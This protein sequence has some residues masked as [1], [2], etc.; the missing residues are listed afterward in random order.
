MRLN[1]LQIIAGGVFLA[2]SIAGSG[3]LPARQIPKAGSLRKKVDQYSIERLLKGE[4]AITTSLADAL[5]E[6]SFLDD[7]DPQFPLPLT[8]MPRA[9]NGNFI[10]IR[11]G[12][13]EFK[14]QSYCLKA[15]TYQPGQGEG[16]LYAP[17]KGP[18]AQIVRHILERS[19]DHPE[20]PQ[21]DIQYLLWAILA[22]T[23]ISAMSRSNQLTALRLLSKEEILALNSGTL[24]IIPDNVLNRALG[25]LP[26]LIQNIIRA[27]NQIRGLLTRA[28]A[29]YDQIERLAVLAGEPPFDKDGRDI[30][31]GRWSYHPNRYFVRYYPSGY[32]VTRRQI[33]VS[34]PFRIHRDSLGRITSIVQD[35]ENRMD[36]EYD[37]T[38]EPLA[39]SGPTPFQA[40]AFRSIRYSGDHPQKL[41]V[42]VKAE[43][44]D[45]GWSFVGNP[46]GQP[47]AEPSSIRYSNL[48]PRLDRAKTYEKELG[49]ISS[50]LKNTGGNIPGD[51]LETGMGIAHLAE[52]LKDIIAAEG[53]PENLSSNEAFYF[54][55]R[56]WMA[57]VV[58][59]AGT[60]GRSAISGRAQTFPTGYGLPIGLTTWPELGW[61]F[62]KGR[63]LVAD[64]SGFAVEPDGQSS[65]SGEGSGSQTGTDVGTPGNSGRQRLGQSDRPSGKPPCSGVV[66]MA[67]GDVQINGQPASDNMISD[68]NGAV[69]T[70][71][72]KS[73]VQID[74]S[75]GSV[76][77]L[78]SNSTLDL[79]GICTQASIGPSWVELA[80]GRIHSLFYKVFGRGPEVRTGNAVNTRGEPDSMQASSF[81]GILLASLSKQPQLDPREIELE[82]VYEELKP[83]EAE[84]ALAQTAFFESIEPH[85]YIYVKVTKGTVVV[86]I[87]DEPEIIVH[88]GEHIYEQLSRYPNPPKNRD[89]VVRVVK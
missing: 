56:A 75:D 42:K 36:V 69:V 76:V 54:I 48:K 77:R 25:N 40:F 19:V 43:W 24:G 12:I 7:F 30:P 18:R 14:A 2:L 55:K 65:G 68:L 3:I 50:G 5:T 81:E 63:L 9:E 79:S 74:V 28:D 47:A 82:G 66:T 86:H 22:R 34:G 78:G 8:L 10:L 67:K 38:I 26:P 49:K 4:P 59:L 33:S 62:P 11:P 89:V 80:R 13:Y 46:A 84:L 27:E 53:A 15:G 32:V 44:K 71:G 61:P 52:G 20:I 31:R 88:A 64:A 83:S 57:A 87:A 85:D 37:Q 21:Q 1:R 72:R 29:T 41:N 60:G 6:V 16:Y 51:R 35:E 45:R 17:L 70:T 23:R 39:L 58:G 73:R